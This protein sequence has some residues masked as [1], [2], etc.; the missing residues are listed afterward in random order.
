MSRPNRPPGTGRADPADPISKS[1]RKRRASR[2][3]VLGQTLARLPAEELAALALPDALR[4]ALADYRRFPSHEARRR[5][6]QFIG[7]LMR[8]IDSAPLESA[9][10]TVQGHS[11]QSRREFHDTERWRERLLAEPQALTDFLAA[12]PGTDSQRLRHHIRHVHDART[13]EQRHSAYRAL[14]RFLRDTVHPV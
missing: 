9:L 8:D 7:R 3:Q 1:E 4:D 10:A 13:E 2:L 6:L 12:Y 11:A 14:F 5:Q